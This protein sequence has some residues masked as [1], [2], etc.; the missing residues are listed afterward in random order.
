MTLEKKKF[1]A[2][3]GKILHL[4]IHSLYTN[5]EIFLRELISNSSDACD[6]LRYLSQQDSGLVK[7]NPDFKIVFSIDKE[8]RLL[9]IFDNGIGMNKQDLIE[10]LGTIARSGTQNFL[11]QLSGNA[12]SD[13]SLI[14]QFGVGFYSSYMVADQVEVMSK[15]AG[16][17]QGYKW[18]SDGMGEY[19]VEEV[20]AD[21]ARGTKVM[22]HIK[23]GEDTYLDHF[24]VKHII[25]I[26]SDHISVPIYFLDAASNNELKLNSSSALWARPKSEITSEQYLEFYKTVS[27]A[28][29]EPWITLHNKNEGIVEFTNLLFIPSTKTFDLF[30]PD[31]KRRV[32]LY[33]K[34]VFIADENMDLVPEYMRFLRGVVDSEG[35]PLNISRETLQHN[36]TIDKIKNAIVKRVL[37]EL[38]KK[39]KDARAEYEGFWAN[40]GAALKEGLCEATTDH[41]QLLDAC[42]FYS[43]LQNKMIGLDEYLSTIKDDQKVI[44]YLSGEDVEKLKNSPQI[45][46]FIS[47]GL[48][49]LLFTDSVDDF[50]VNIAAKYKDHEFKSVTRV[51]VD[52]DQNQEPEKISDAH[53]K[54]LDFFKETLGD[55]VKDVRLSK[56]LTGSPVCL[57][58]AE[59][60]MDMRMERFLLEQKQI[61]AGTAKILEINA[62][63]KIITHIEKNVGKSE[64]AELVKLLFDQACIIEG[65]AVI[66]AASFSKRMNKLIEGSV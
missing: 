51:D 38:A 46:G 4:M 57:A 42:L 25:K 21:F 56:K 52:L 55:S 64:T 12:K 43:V 33:I 44:Y 14:G 47:K 22:V 35:L 15:K 10:N 48:D 20:D 17:A 7:D 32:K 16:E 19:S 18:T 49:V 6:K 8:K 23:E 59:G 9:T 40:F 50:W 30:H 27:F 63:H 54:L 3:V 26:Y 61:K 36:A 53:Q 2:E 37:G 65:E 29:D 41:D 5:K 58:V 13:S 45:E 62:N 39:K 11:S 24:R 1:D 34:R 28:A 60:A 66:D 31:R